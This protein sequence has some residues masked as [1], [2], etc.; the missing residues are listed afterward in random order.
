MV[1]IIN[2]F[3]GKLKKSH[4]IVNIIHDKIRLPFEYFMWFFSS[5]GQQ[6]RAFQCDLG[7]IIMRSSDCIAFAIFNTS[8]CKQ[9][10][11]RKLV[12][13]SENHFPHV[14]E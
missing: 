3:K 12:K 8:Q 13:R 5:L 14:C 11:V 6:H 1:F 7:S 4:F 2:Q 10:R 9:T